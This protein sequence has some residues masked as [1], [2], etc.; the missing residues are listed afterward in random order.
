MKYIG[1]SDILKGMS[2][3]DSLDKPQYDM[4][5]MG[6]LVKN[7]QYKPLLDYV[8]CYPTT[9]DRERY[10]ISLQKCDFLPVKPQNSAYSLAIKFTKTMYGFMKG[11]KGSGIFKYNTSSTAG[12]PYNRITDSNG[13]LLMHKVDLVNSPDFPKE[14]ERGHTPIFQGTTKFEY[15]PIS[16]LKNKKQRTFFGSEGPECFK[17]KILWDNC[18]SLMTARSTNWYT[19]WSRYGFVKQYGGINRLAQAHLGL[20]KKLERDSLGFVHMTS[21]VS[22]WDRVLPV[23]PEVYQIRGELYGEMNDL[24]RSWFSGI[25]QSLTSPYFSTTEGD[26]FQRFC[27]NM[28]G[29]G[30]T[31]SD[32]T[33]GHTIIKFYVFIKLYYDMYDQYPT[34]DDITDYVVISLYGD[35]DLTSLYPEDWI[36][37]A[38]PLELKNKIRDIYL[39][40]G[41]TIK[42]SAFTVQD[43]ID[44]LEFLGSTFRN[45]GTDYYYGQPRYDKICSSI[46]QYLEKQKTGEAYCSTSMAV[47]YLI[48]GLTDPIALLIK[49]F[50]RDYARQIIVNHE[51][52]LDRVNIAYLRDIAAGTFNSEMLATG[53]ES[54]LGCALLSEE[55]QYE[56]HNFKFEFLSGFIPLSNT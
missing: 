20:C 55:F 10:Y 26:I 46:F 1:R 54:N 42:E 38:D 22:G 13:K 51:H 50:N 37:S 8:T 12:V 39:E 21:D 14:M 47:E 7:D 24:E 25:S 48:C 19:C 36:E 43:T 11:I 34:Y 32:N 5:A 16:D 2:F 15:M 31:T 41:L 52:E 53:F 35:D 33:I 27:G 40:F 4:L 18:D 45:D 29:S 6:I 28:S 17:Q 23:M 56:L 9:H 3:K 49:Q 30:K 44:G